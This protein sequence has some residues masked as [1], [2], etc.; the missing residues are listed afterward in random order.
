MGYT[1]VRVEGTARASAG[2]VS[3]DVDVERVFYLAQP[4]DPSE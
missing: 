1:L 3:R 4:P 2:W